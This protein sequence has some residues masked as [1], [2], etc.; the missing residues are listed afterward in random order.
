MIGLSLLVGL[1]LYIWLSVLIV[2][3]TWNLASTKRFRIITRCIT[4]FFVLWLPVTEPMISYVVYKNYADKHAGPKIYRTVQDVDRIHLDSHVSPDE[5][6]IWGTAYGNKRNG[7]AYDYVEYELKG[8]IFEMYFDRRN[9]PI[10]QHSKSRYFVKSDHA[11]EARYYHA[12]EYV[13]YD[14]SGDILAICQ[15][16]T[17]CGGGFL[18]IEVEHTGKMCRGVQKEPDGYPV[19]K[20]IH[21][22]LQ[23]PY[24]EY[25]K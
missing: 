14:Y 4:V 17:W 19:G 24:V 2:W 18:G 10:L 1:V 9:E 6:A 20:Y 15:Y 8:Q 21:S 7:M 5:V 16:V 23:P 11:I 22:V 12:E 3:K 13:V 25:A